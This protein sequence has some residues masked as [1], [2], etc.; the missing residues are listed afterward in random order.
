MCHAI[1]FTVVDANNKFSAF[2]FYKV[3]YHVSILD[4]G[5]AINI[6]REAK[7]SRDLTRIMGRAVRCVFAYAIIANGTK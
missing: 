4:T 3:V 6:V 2:F 7:L 5:E 1:P